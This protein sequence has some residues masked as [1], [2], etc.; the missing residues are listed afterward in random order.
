MFDFIL[1]SILWFLA[2]YGLI[3]LINFLL[4]LHKKTNLSFNENSF[5]ITVHNQEN[6][7]EFFIRSLLSKLLDNN[8]NISNIII[9]DL[10][11]TDNTLN[12]LNTLTKDFNFIKVLTLDEY[13]K[14]LESTK[15][16]NIMHN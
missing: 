16:C 2:L 13:I 3:E 15:I 5:I 9:V 12:L 4:N 11:S 6:N 8:L 7:I 10:N 1:T 14:Y